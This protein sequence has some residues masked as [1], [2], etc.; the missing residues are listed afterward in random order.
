MLCGLEVLHGINGKHGEQHSFPII[1]GN[2]CEARVSRYN[3]KLMLL[4]ML[5]FDT[6]QYLGL[7]AAKHAC[8]L[9]FKYMY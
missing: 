2:E 8:A 7:R 9:T 5:F 6:V 3:G 4:P 1:A